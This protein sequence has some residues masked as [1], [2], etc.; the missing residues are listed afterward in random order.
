MYRGTTSAVADRL[1][2]RGDTSD[3]DE[4]VGDENDKNDVG[5]GRRLPALA[6]LLVRRRGLTTLGVGVGLDPSVVELGLSM[7]NDLECGED[8]NGSGF[9][10]RS[11]SSLSS[12]SQSSPA[13][14]FG[15]AN[16]S[17]IRNGDG[18]SPFKFPWPALPL[19]ST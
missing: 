9:D 1:G 19:T 13:P 8:P 11:S 17:S 6:L 18:L 5:P 10:L 4:L 15:R 2:V 7:K 14:P 12:E 3:E 16:S